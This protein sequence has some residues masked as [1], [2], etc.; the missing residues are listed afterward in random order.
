[1]KLA[2]LGTG[3]LALELSLFFHNEGAMVKMIGPQNPGGKI[4]R[5][6]EN[7][8]SAMLKVSS[9]VCTTPWGLEFTGFQVPSEITYKE[10]W[11]NYY[12]KIAVFLSAERVFVPRDLIRVQ[13]Q[14]LHPEESIA[15]R[16]RLLDLF[17]VTYG[18]N[19]SGLVEQQLAE[20]PELAD[21][22]G[23]DI[24]ES[25]KNQ[26]ESFEDFDLVIDARGPFQ[27]PLRMGAGLEFALN[28]HPLSEMGLIH[29]GYD[30]LGF[31]S[32]D[33]KT[34]TIVGDGEVAALQLCLLEDW[35]E[36]PGKELNIV[37][38]Q[39]SA[40][41]KMLS[42]DKVDQNLK[43]KVRTL[44]TKY[45]KNWRAE[46]EQVEQELLKWRELEPH[47]KAKVTRPEFPEPKIKLYEGYTITSVDK[48]TDREQVFLTLELPAWKNEDGDRKELITLSQDR[49]LACT[50]Y[51][52]DLTPIRS[53]KRVNHEPGFM[54]FHWNQE[55]PTL[56]NGL[57]QVKALI[58]QV[59]T[60]FSKG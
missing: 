17:R 37:T 13:K 52:S 15:K 36:N 48:L 55:I 58:D 2:V 44:I 21:K 14:F 56:E 50:G 41:E 24:L 6:A 33:H 40:F 29:Y 45:M 31:G 25:L 8:N 4:Q 3:A 59:F 28:E 54:E 34:L 16:T 49:V 27:A 5:L 46:C 43:D 20:N 51:E 38:Y 7:K 10:L 26:V 42:D 1:M 11:E 32:D 19:A 39:S 12:Q 23:A 57:D 18:L 47:V 35:L 9:S 60:Y 22:I 53:I 30:F